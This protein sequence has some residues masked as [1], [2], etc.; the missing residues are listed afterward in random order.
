M[1]STERAKEEL[2]RWR[3]YFGLLAAIVIGLTGWL[4]QGP[5]ASASEPEW[6]RPGA[7]VAAIYF[8]ALLIWIDRTM[9]RL[10]GEMESPVDGDPGRNPSG[11]P[12]G[13]K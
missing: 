6:L 7:F 4:Y 13:A 10:I 11:E 3:L 8:T 1:N 12:G 9:V 5:P 2:A